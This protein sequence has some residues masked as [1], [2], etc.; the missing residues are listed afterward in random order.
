MNWK[1]EATKKL[2]R[3]PYM[4]QASENIP[5]EIKRLERQATAIRSAG[6]NAPIICGKN[7]REDMLLDNLVERQELQWAL[8]N[9]KDWMGVTDRAL[10]T[11]RQDEREILSR[12]LIFPEEGALA[13]LCTDLGVESSSIYRRRD[14]ALRKFTLALYGSLDS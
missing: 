12:M 8:Q 14:A 5:R 6:T 13:S 2:S 7:G 11:L 1:E 3:Y 4:R 10:S 9:A